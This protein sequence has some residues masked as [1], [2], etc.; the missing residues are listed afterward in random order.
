MAEQSVPVQETN[1]FC[2]ASLSA[3]CEVCSIMKGPIM[4]R[5]SRA[6]HHK[7]VLL[8]RLNYRQAKRC[9]FV[10]HGQAY[11]LGSAPAPLFRTF[12]LTYRPSTW[13]SRHY[14]IVFLSGSTI[15]FETKWY[16][17]CAL[18]DEN[19]TVPLYMSAYEAQQAI[20]C[21]CEARSHQANQ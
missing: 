12:V 10:C 5:Q 6:P 2:T 4:P 21:Q 8:P 3:S 11:H 16:I 9:W 19:V 14:C 17:L 15:D 13:G 18:R 1:I 7:D 20:A